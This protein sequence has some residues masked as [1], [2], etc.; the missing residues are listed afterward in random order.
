MKNVIKGAFSLSLALGL[1]ATSAH[2]VYDLKPYT[3]L[4]AG[5]SNLTNTVFVVVKEDVSHS[6]CSE[7]NFIRLPL[8]NQLSDTFLETAKEAITSGKKIG[9]SFSGSCTNGAA[10]PKNFSLRAQ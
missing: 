1:V 4:E 3:V 2:A 7:S 10:T 9:V 5:A 6:G 8:S